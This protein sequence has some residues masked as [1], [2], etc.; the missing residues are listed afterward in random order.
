MKATDLASAR[1]VKWLQANLGKSCTAPLTGT[2]ARALRA[3]V[4]IVEL[5]AQKNSA[6]VLEA[7]RLV[8]LCMQPATRELAYHGI[9]MVRD[10]S[11]RDEMWAEAGLEPLACVR[12]CEFE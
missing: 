4:E 8:V 2:D 11:N 9:A 5:Y 12:R 6:G 3:A 7:F 1:I 10:W